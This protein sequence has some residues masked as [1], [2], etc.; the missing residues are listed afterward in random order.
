[1]SR[2][3]WS[4]LLCLAVAWAL[5]GC[6]G[7]DGLVVISPTSFDFGR[8]Q[9][10]DRPTTVLTV[11]NNSDRVVNLMP[12]PNCGCFA[13]ERGR[14]LAPLDP[15]ASMEVRVLFDSTAK[16]PGPVQGKW[17]TFHLDHPKQRGIVVPLEG[18]IFQ[19][20]EVRPQALS[21][22]RI[23]GRDRNYEPRTVTVHPRSGY[24]LA[25]QRVVCSPDVFDVEQRTGTQGATDIVL[26]LRR[27]VA[28]RPLGAFRADIRLELELTPPG[29]EPFTQRPIVEVTGFWALKP[30]GT[31][32]R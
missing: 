30:D 3:F 5:C 22:Q 9:Q 28:P 15:G 4:A 24:V 19:S 11:T 27:T 1:M 29:G 10:G 26:T 13:V 31:A 25:V 23:D 16:P 18:E 14:S 7:N 32:L 8:V 12:Q 17:V 21:Y 20:Y 6:G 2:A